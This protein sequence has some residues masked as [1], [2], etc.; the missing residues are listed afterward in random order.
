MAERTGALL[1]FKP[2]INEDDVIEALN[3]PIFEHLLDTNYF[4]GNSE[5]ERIANM[6]H[7][8]DDEW[9]GPVFYLP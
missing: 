2:G 5:Q 7:T 1:V 9:G 6:I 3:N 8:Y 4:V